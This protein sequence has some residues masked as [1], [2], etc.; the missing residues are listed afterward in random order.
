MSEAQDHSWFAYLQVTDTKD[1]LG[2]KRRK[3]VEKIGSVRSKFA[4]F[5]A[6]ISSL[7]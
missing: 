1:L 2:E 7:F 3:R 4:E 5:N 6:E